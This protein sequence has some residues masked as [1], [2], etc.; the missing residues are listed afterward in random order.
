[1]RIEGYGVSMGSHYYGLKSS[2]EEPLHETQASDQNSGSDFKSDASTKSPD[3]K[4]AVTTQQ[5]SENL[6][7]RGLSASLL[8]SI[9]QTAQIG[10]NLGFNTVAIEAEALTFEA[11]ATIKT[12]TQSIDLSLNVSLSRSFVEQTRMPKPENFDSIT[13]LLDPI[14]LDLGGTFPS[15]SSKTFSF[16]LDSD[17]TEDQISMLK[18]GSSFLALDKN[19]SGSIDNGTELFGAKSGNGF[20]ELRAYDED[21][22]GWIDANDPIFNK[23]QIWQKTETTNN[24]LALGEVGI[25]AIFLG[26]V[27]TPFSLK[28]SSNTLQGVMRQSSFFLFED[29]KAGM[30]SQIDMATSKMEDTQKEIAVTVNSLKKLQGM[31]SYQNQKQSV[32]GDARLEKLQETLKTLEA[33]FQKANEEEKT[34]LEV[35]INSI[36]T[37]IMALVA[38]KK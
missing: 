17:G 20:G 3:V 16:D 23:L 30:I 28:G 24:L 8:T 37:Q 9:K 7:L 38:S 33:K 4:N 2:I 34:S 12:Q 15:L 19:R 10:E 26:D 31:S 1:M 22:N 32:S 27:A 35:Q 13:S 25:G 5:N 18:E 36:N 21:K 14:I 29:G 6:L 11:K